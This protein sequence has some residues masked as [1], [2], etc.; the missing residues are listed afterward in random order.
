MSEQLFS[1]RQLEKLSAALNQGAANASDAF[2]RWL[3]RPSL[4]TLESVEQLPLSEATG[5]FGSDQPVCVGS[6]QMPRELP[7]RLLVVFDDASGYAL[8]DM[9]LRQTVG[10]A[11]DWGE[12]ETS[13]ALESTNILC[14]AYLNA[15][16][17]DLSDQE[18]IPDELIPEPP[19]FH[20]DF[21]ESMLQFALMG[22]AMS[23]ET[24]FLVRTKF[25]VDDEPLNWTLLWVP[26]PETLGQLAKI[27]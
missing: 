27:D 22:Q 26:E 12:L 17:A 3:G 11:Q 7:G 25:Q 18:T 13:A 21:A 2:A 5:L 20:R 9:V 15:L 8:A 16:V 19:E 1:D 24:A 6:M 4:M 10:T 23:G 14:C